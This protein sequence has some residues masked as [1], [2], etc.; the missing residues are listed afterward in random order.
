MHWSLV[1]HSLI[2]WYNL[3]FQTLSWASGPSMLTG[4]STKESRVVWIVDLSRREIRSSSSQAGSPDPDP[5]TPCGSSTLWMWL[6][7]T[8]WPPSQVTHH[9]GYVVTVAIIWFKVKSFCVP[10]KRIQAVLIPLS[11]C[12]VEAD[13]IQ[14]HSFN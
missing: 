1:D 2:T 8:Y 5:Q 7:K 3:V 13:F 6:T 10:L 4:G 14:F 12:S 11:F 9:F